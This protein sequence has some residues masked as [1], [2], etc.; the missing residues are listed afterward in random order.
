MFKLLFILGGLLCLIV[1]PL[2]YVLYYREHK[3]NALMFYTMLFA[4]AAILWG[5][6]YMLSA[7]QQ[8]MTSDACG[9]IQNYQIYRTAGNPNSRKPFQRVEIL[10]DGAKYSKHLRVDGSLIKKDVGAHVCFEFYDRKKNPHMT[11]SKV[12]TWSD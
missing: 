8:D 10:F 12:I 3:T 11:D 2:I 6:F 5:I 1:W 9:V 7:Q 4:P